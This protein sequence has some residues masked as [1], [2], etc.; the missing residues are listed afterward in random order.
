MIVQKIVD[1][2]ALSKFFESD[3]VLYAYLLGDL[4]PELFGDTEY[5]VGIES[6]K[7]IAAL[8]IYKAF[9]IQVVQGLTSGS[10]GEELWRGVIKAGVLP[11]RFYAH[12]RE[13]HERILRE[14]FDFGKSEELYKMQLKKSQLKL[15]DEE[16]LSRA[17]KLDERH[18]DE[19]KHL[20][21]SV[22]GHEY[23]DKRLL[24]SGVSQGVYADGLLVCFAGAH[25][26]ST[27]Y[28]VTSLGGICTHPNYRVR[29]Y[30]SAA[31]GALLEALPKEIETICLNV[32]QENHPAIKL[33]Q[34]L[35]FTITHEYSEAIM[36]SR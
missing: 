7:I 32:V 30:A 23:V 22:F 24:G 28:G 18:V 11:R 17:V 36:E 19:V 9:E 29:G 8:L 34:R 6:D 3:R 14:H 27:D 25:V 12:F 20:V 4:E 5:W 13:E 16:L 1:K 10:P 26:L 2:S 31:S 35:G 33:Y 15:P 21:K